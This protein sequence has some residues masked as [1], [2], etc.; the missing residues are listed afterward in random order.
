MTEESCGRAFA[1]GLL[2]WLRLQIGLIRR[3]MPN[4][5]ANTLQW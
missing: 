2:P 4:Y 3:M 5:Q 1:I